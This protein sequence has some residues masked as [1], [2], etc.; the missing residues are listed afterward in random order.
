MHDDEFLVRFENLTLAPAEFGHAGH[1]RLGWLNL[2]R[3]DRASAIARTCA[4]IRAY[5][6]HLGAPDKFHWTVTEAL[7]RLM[8]A[9]G[10]RL[11]GD[12]RLLLARHY[13]PQLL[14]SEDARR[15]FVGPDRAALPV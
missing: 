8:A 6:T 10:G 7:L 14:A 4:G 15:A 12:A 2:Q 13:S 1:M 9:Q 11:P 3:H 5:A